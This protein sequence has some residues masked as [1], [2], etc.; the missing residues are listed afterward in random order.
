LAPGQEEGMKT[1][2]PL[3]D[4]LP[5]KFRLF[6]KRLYFQIM[7]DLNAKIAFEKITRGSK[8]ID[9]SLL[10]LSLGACACGSV[11]ERDLAKPNQ[12][13]AGDS[14][15]RQA[16]EKWTDALEGLKGNAKTL[17]RVST[18]MKA[19]LAAATDEW[20]PGEWDYGMKPPRG[21]LYQI[22]CSVIPQ[23]GAILSGC[24]DKI[25]DWARVLENYCVLC[26]KWYEVAPRLREGEIQKTTGLLNIVKERTGR[27]HFELMAPLIN[28]GRRLAGGSEE[29]AESLRSMWRRE[30]RTY[31][32][33][34]IR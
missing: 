18:Q 27:C 23:G 11:D 7:R 26:K 25:G 9:A 20:P 14:Q 4:P 13:Y 19:Y 32:H 2:F 15:Q 8:A 1:T 34:R 10:L 3:K 22:L 29:T 31:K 33:S 30:I 28:V 5:L 21:Q 16:W 17:R 24:A 12:R 6:D